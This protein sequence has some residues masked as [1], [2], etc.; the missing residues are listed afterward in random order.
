MR[1]VVCWVIPREEGVV[2]F[3]GDL[4]DALLD[5]WFEVPEFEIISENINVEVIA[6]WSTVLY[7]SFIEGFEECLYAAIET[8]EESVEEVFRRLPFVEEMEE[9]AFESCEI[10]FKFLQVF[11]EF[12]EVAREE[13]AQIFRGEQF[14][15]VVVAF[16]F[17]VAT[18]HSFDVLFLEHADSVQL[19]FIQS[20]EI[21]RCG[22]LLLL[23]REELGCF[24]LAG[25]DSAFEGGWVV[26]SVILE[27]SVAVD[28]LW[29]AWGMS[30]H[31]RCCWNDWRRVW[32][33]WIWWLL[34]F[35]TYW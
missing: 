9:A 26:E 7:D 25:D 16:E 2:E 27:G 17:Y 21:V 32:T 30:Y 14:Q 19:D 5:D 10:C 28:Y 24:Y 4:N 20:C 33:D 22:V 8:D 1:I 23:T 35:L 31:S 29:T 12:L 15:R 13:S 34:Y 6:G 11:L 18:E 3:I